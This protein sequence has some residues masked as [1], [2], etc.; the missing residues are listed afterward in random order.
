MHITLERHDS[1]LKLIRVQLRIRELTTAGPYDE[2]SRDW[3]SEQRKP[4][5]RYLSLVV[6]YLEVPRFPSCTFLVVG[7]FWA[8]HQ[9]GKI[10]IL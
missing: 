7:Y 2:G 10:R 1:T 6:S 8:T 3:N 9:K 4:M 5:Q